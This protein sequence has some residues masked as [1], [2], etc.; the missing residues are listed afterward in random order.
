MPSISYNKRVSAPVPPP[1]IPPIPIPIPTNSPRSC[2]TL[3]NITSLR[4]SGR[5]ITI[6]LYS[7]LL[8]TMAR[9]A[10]R[11]SRHQVNWSHERSHRAILLFGRGSNRDTVF[12][13]ECDFAGNNCFVATPQAELIKNWLEIPASFPL[14]RVC[15]LL[16]R[17]PRSL[18]GLFLRL[19]VYD[20]LLNEGLQQMFT[21]ESFRPCYGSRLNDL[22]ASFA[23]QVIML[24]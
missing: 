4:R 23:G 22:D 5:P 18:F 15:F 12:L 9:L 14:Y 3:T 13:R 2:P 20:R 7:R 6:I 11:L 8:Q 16:A 17:G 10:S 1:I 24:E 21:I 19:F